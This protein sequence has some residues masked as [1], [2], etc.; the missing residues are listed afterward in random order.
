MSARS[1]M[2]VE[3]G[4]RDSE[5]SVQSS[6][7]PTHLESTLLGT[8]DGSANCTTDDYIIITLSQDARFAS[9]QV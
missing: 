9:S 3:L 5:N 7:E 1:E 8:S 4:Q 6:L 2:R